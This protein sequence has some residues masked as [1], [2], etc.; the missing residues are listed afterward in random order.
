[1]SEF[2]LELTNFFLELFLNV[3]R[4]STSV[5]RLSG[6]EPLQPSAKT[7]ESAKNHYS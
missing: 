6:C 7:M 2:V 1:M 3:F 4:H 5:T